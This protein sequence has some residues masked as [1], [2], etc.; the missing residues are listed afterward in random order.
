VLANQV[1][2]LYLLL[3]SDGFS[4]ITTA[5]RRSRIGSLGI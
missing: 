3:W 2:I 4:K 1:V 5:E